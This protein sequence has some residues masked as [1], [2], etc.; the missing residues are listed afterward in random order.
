VTETHS[1]TGV[2]AS[3]LASSLY[4]LGVCCMPYQGLGNDFAR[5][6]ARHRRR[7]SNRAIDRTRRR[8]RT[9]SKASQYFPWAVRSN[10]FGVRWYRPPGLASSSIQSEP[11]GAYSISRTRLPMVQR[12]AAVAPPLP[13]NVTRTSAMGPKPLINALPS[14]GKTLPL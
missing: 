2:Y 8:K 7:K 14:H 6:A 10:Y 12:W 13:S 5:R 11:S 3:V 4:R 9:S 1:I